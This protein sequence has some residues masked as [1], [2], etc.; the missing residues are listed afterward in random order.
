MRVYTYSEARQR[1]TDVLNRARSEGQA[2]IRR[3]DGQL[4]EVK[5]VAPVGSPLNVPAAGP[6]LSRAEIVELVCESRRSAG[7]LLAR[8]A[9]KFAPRQKPGRS[10]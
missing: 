7:R 3:R 2:R 6:G 10:S 5:P 1:L 8:R 9:T 4:F